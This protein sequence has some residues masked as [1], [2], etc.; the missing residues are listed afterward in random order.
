[1][2][3]LAVR[4]RDTP[5]QRL[6][7]ARFN[8]I[9]G[10]IPRD[11]NKLMQVRILAA[12][13]CARAFELL[14]TVGSAVP[15]RQPARGCGATTEGQWVW[16]CVADEFGHMVGR[17]A[18]QAMGALKTLRLDHN[19]FLHVRSVCTHT[20]SVQTVMPARTITDQHG[21]TKITVGF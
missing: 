3:Q 11:I 8:R 16:A 20:H 1:M 9:R 2:R 15:Q 19:T 12:M 5:N 13:T 10:T 4:S 6:A 21:E 18:V 17:L 14:R 7:L